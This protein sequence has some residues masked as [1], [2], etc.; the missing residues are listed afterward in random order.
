[1]APNVFSAEWHRKD[2]QELGVQNVEWLILVDALF[3]LDEGGEGSPTIH[4]FKEHIK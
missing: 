2:F 1:M 4:L 3:L